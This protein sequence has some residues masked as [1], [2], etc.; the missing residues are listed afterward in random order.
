MKHILK[1]KGADVE[2]TTDEAKQLFRELQEVFG[3]PPIQV[4]P[5][6]PPP[7]WPPFVPPTQFPNWPPRPP[8]PPQ[9]PDTFPDRPRLICADQLGLRNR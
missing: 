4:Q 5:Q 7:K 9:Y 2:L 1:I 8:R 6:N 3:P